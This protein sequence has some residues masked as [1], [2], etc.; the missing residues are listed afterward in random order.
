[1]TFDM[2]RHSAVSLTDVEHTS[3][4]CVYVRNCQAQ[5]P[6]DNKGSYFTDHGFFQT[7]QVVS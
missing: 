3:D 5:E 7:L 2:T 1:M 6:A 4:S